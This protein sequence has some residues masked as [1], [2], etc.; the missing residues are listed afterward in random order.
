M[1][2]SIILEGE[3]DVEGVEAA[4]TTLTS[5]I[6]IEIAEED[7]GRLEQ[8]I[9]GELSDILEGVDRSAYLKRVELWRRM[10]LAEPES[11]TKSEPWPGASNVE[12]PIASQKVNTVRAKLLSAFATKRPFFGVTTSR[13]DARAKA[14]AIEKMLN[15]MA[16]SPT[17]LDLDNVNKSVLYNVARLGTAFVKVPWLTIDEPVKTRDAATG[18]VSL[19]KKRTHNGP[20]VIEIRVEDFVMRSIFDDIE[21]AP[22]VGSRTYLTRSEM[23][24]RVEAG[25]YDA[26]DGLLEA[27]VV[28]TMEESRA[29]VAER[30]GFASS[31]P[32]EEP[33]TALYEVFEL[34]V[35][36]DADKDGFS[37]DLKVWFERKTGKILRLEE[38]LLGRRDIVALR[39]LPL[40]GSIYGVGICQLLEGLQQTA[41]FA[42][43]Y[44][45][46]NLQLVLTPVYKRRIGAM[47]S[48]RKTLE[49]GQ[50]LDLAELDDVMPMV[51]PDV[52]GSTYALENLVRDYAD[53]I[54]G[55]N[56]PMSGY[57]DSSLKSG[58]NAA[59]LMFLA[60]QGNSVLNAVLDGVQRDYDQ[61]GQIA[62][63]QCAINDDLVDYTL[64]E[65]EEAALLREVFAMPVEELPTQFHFTVTTADISRSDEAKQQKVAAGT[66]LYQQYGQIAMSLTQMI[67][68]PQ[69]GPATKQMAMQFLQ[70]ATVFA[71]RS[72]RLL[73][74]EDVD[75]LLPPIGR[76]NEGEVES[77]QTG[78]M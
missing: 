1:S 75:R 14:N 37:E 73:E 58:A 74:V 38:N 56:D 78:A 34:Y 44:R 17:Q 68:S 76:T 13:N 33:A 64:V 28:D 47:K 30:E 12:P 25:V 36:F 2:D 69:V 20:K 72:L 26:V 9:E 54:S 5:A 10:S 24:A 49:P 21:R 45:V 60:Q 46:N 71:D 29:D 27:A 22:L 50:F 4:K 19:K 23:E 40:P 31:M 62:L 65:D 61:I 3:G 6:G 35:R 8:Y 32:T 55:A 53:R 52:T 63:L 51:T 59:S 16:K 7:R 18:V 43:N 57:G 41:S 70:G 66:A 48:K 77:G 39:Y 11:A 67:E 15:A 42:F